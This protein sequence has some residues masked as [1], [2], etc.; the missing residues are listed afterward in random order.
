MRLEKVTLL[1]LMLL[2]VV[3]QPASAQDPSTKSNKALKAYQKAEAAY[4]QRDYKL[5]EDQL[6]KATKRDDEFIEAWMLMGAIH[7]DQKTYNQAVVAYTKVLDIDSASIPMVYYMLGDLYYELEE[8]HL[9]A[10]HYSSYLKF[11]G[12]SEIRRRLAGQSL[13]HCKMA[14]EAIE[15]P[16]NLPVNM[17]PL[18]N[19]TADEYINFVDETESSLFVT[20]KELESIDAHGRK[21]FSENF[22]LSLKHNGDWPS[23]KALNLSWLGQYNAG[24]MSLSVDGRSMYFTGC[25]WPGGLGSCDLYLSQ[26][27]GESWQVPMNMRRPINT[28]DWESQAVLSSDASRLFFASRRTG[29]K[30]GSDIWM[31]KKLNNG[32]WSPP[33]NLGD[34]INTP[35]NEMAPFLHAD[36][37]TLY[38][39]SNGHGGLG[40]YDLFVSR[41][42]GVGR[43]QGVVNVGHPLNTSS[44]E[45]NMFLNLEGTK[46]WVSSNRYGG[47]GGFDIY[48]VETDERMK[49]GRVVFFKGLVMD[50]NDRK[51]LDARVL[52]SD[53]QMGMSV[54]ST[55]ADPISGYFMLALHPSKH[56]AINITYPGYLFYSENL[57]FI[58]D[59]ASSVEKEFLLKPLEKGKSIVLNNIFF[60]FNSSELKVSSQVELKRLYLLLRDNPSLKI[61]ISGHT[62]NI[63]TDAYNQKLSLERALALRDYLLERAI[64]SERIEVLGHGS[65]KPLNTNDTEGGRAVNR[66]IEISIL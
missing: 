41:Q 54:D 63:G 21:Q 34:S 12:I 38:F 20:R 17:G 10:R 2:L 7:Y 13:K 5:A 35:D 44:D 11:Y 56:Y 36:G 1:M 62:D 15:N 39:S 53:L 4:F 42:D 49:P 64:D 48:E 40:G 52:V 6:I 31:S 3:A 24:S 14:I 43:W 47:Y 18:I 59:T 8:Y 65:E 25:Y 51:P 29:G 32:N 26:K 30:G 66:R 28:N 55:R 61:R 45:I 37:K 33:I 60:D 46:A 22:Y 23:P 50:T 57:D 19:T 27:L 16:S 9:A 58:S